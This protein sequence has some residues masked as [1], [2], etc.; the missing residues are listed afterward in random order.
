MIVFF[1]LQY[2]NLNVIETKL[3]KQKNY[4]FFC[5][6]ALS[7]SL[8]VAVVWFKFSCGKLSFTDYS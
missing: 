7:L 1:I 2:H 6:F 8:N 4:R 3:Y 5:L